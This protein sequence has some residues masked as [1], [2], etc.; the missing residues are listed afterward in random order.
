MQ[1]KYANSVRNEDN[2][3]KYENKKDKWSPLL[4]FLVLD[5]RE[6]PWN[7]CQ[8]KQRTQHKYI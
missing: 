7:V 5:S 8:E 2:V 3:P 1:V 6:D 4:F